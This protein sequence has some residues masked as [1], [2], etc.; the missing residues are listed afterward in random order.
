MTSEV[1]I[2][3]KHA[4]VLAADSAVTTSP[5]R[6]GE[7]PRYSKTATKLFELANHGSVAVMIYGSAAVDLVPWEVVVKLFRT[8]L[9]SKKLP[10]LDSYLNEL[11]SFI[12]SSTTLFS[13]DILT[14]LT[15]AR[16]LEA[17]RFVFQ[18][19]VDL[20]RQLTDI[21]VSL[22]DRKKV[23]G[24]A[25]K[26][27]REDLA[28]RPVSGSL[29]EAQLVAA[30]ADMGPWIASVESELKNVEAA[31]AVSAAELTELALEALYKRADQFLSPTG[32]VVAGYGDDDIFP[33]YV[34]VE[35]Y[36]HIGEELYHLKGK[37]FK[38]THT[39]SSSIEAFAQRSMIDVFTD[40]FGFPLWKILSDE[41]LEKLQSLVVKLK[42]EGVVIA[43]E[44]AD[45]AVKEVHEE[46]MSG[47]TKKNYSQNW[48]PLTEVLASLGVQEMAHLGE[49][50]LTLQALKERVTSSSESVGGPIDVAAITK[51]EGLVW[52]KRKHFFEQ[53]LNVRYLTR[54]QRTLHT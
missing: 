39:Q 8:K 15:G 27:M 5:L 30:K 52:L 10:D 34:A 44:V 14:K 45:S 53:Q 42:D 41:S 9:G 49:T 37:N 40:G 46:F 11:I 3:N 48:H 25:V 36:G 32:V 22:D 43:T 33:G 29:S 24:G 31:R 26:T 17:A 7:H 12:G 21:T 18:W 51:S 50:L 13:S 54:V 4:I 28:A 20:D 2:L 6:D 1:L 47:W 16:L 35:V 38:V 19:A 23:W